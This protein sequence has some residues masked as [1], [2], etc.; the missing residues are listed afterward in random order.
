[1]DGVDPQALARA[2]VGLTDWAQ[3]FAIDDSPDPLRE[4]LREHMGGPAKGLPVVSRALE[5]YQRANFQLAIDRYLEHAGRE[6]EL[7]GLP[8]THGYRVGLAELAR[9]VVHGPWDREGAEEGPVE[10]EPVDVDEL[11]IMCVA[12]GLWLI[13]DEREPLLLMLRRS[14]EGPHHAELGI[15]IMARQREIAERTLGEIER[16]M[17]EHNVYRGRILILSRSQ[18]GGIG[19]EV[20]RLPKVTRERIVFPSGVLERIERHTKTFEEH[21]DALRA[22]G[23]HLKRGL[24]LHGPPGTGKTLSVMYLSTLMPGRTVLLLTGNTLGAIEPACEMARELA[25]SMLVLEDVDLVAENRMMGHPTSVLFELLNQ[26]DGLQEDIDVVFVLTTNRPEIIEPA[27]ASRPGRIDLA[28]ETPL[29]DS[30]GRSRLLD[31][32]GEGLELNLGDRATIISA[33]EGATPA[34]IREVLRRASLAAAENGDATRITD[35]LLV[36]AIEDLHL[37]DDSLAR[38]ALGAPNAASND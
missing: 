25:P 27:L 5:G 8:M 29:P 37:A 20:Q 23:R 6:A 32:Y 19:V 18:W 11:R 1:V 17:A 2:I 30:E 4:R 9:G 13:K 7:I 26:M 10:F 28:V 14:D 31:L 22:A 38:S 3:A 21:V 33:T 12:A 24:L 34:F 35:Q 36:S 16:L 15:E